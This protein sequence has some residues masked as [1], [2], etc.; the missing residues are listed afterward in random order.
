MD[1]K[2]FTLIE[3]LVVVA[4]IGILAAIAIPN[5]LNA[6]TRARQ[7]KTM[8][9]IRTLATAWETR[10]VEVGRYN[11]AAAAAGYAGID[12][13]VNMDDLEIALKPTYVRSFPK[14]DAWDEP[15]ACFT[16]I[17]WN[18][19]VSAQKYAIISSGADKKFDP[20]TPAGSTTNFDCDIV[21]VSGSFLTYPGGVQ[22]Q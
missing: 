9:E 8:A 7:R 11:A 21:F 4:I 22:Q 13:A 6:M 1:K 3:L 5:L 10:N 12:Q 17:S 19:S 20:A 14:Q 2:G 16:D 15:F 18:D